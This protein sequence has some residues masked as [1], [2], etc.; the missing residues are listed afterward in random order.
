VVAA[1]EP[2]GPPLRPGEVWS[3]LSGAVILVGTPVAHPPVYGTR[4]AAPE[5]EVLVGEAASTA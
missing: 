2:R 1:R 3:L 4:V 5:L